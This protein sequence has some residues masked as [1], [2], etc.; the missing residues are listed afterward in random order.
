M[1]T[2]RQLKVS[3]DMGHELFNNMR[4]GNWMLDYTVDRLSFMQ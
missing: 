1:R 4:E 3:G 2:I